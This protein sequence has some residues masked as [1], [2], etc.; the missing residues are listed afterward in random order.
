[1]EDARSTR[2]TPGSNADQSILL[3]FSPPNNVEF[4]WRLRKLLC[5]QMNVHDTLTASRRSYSRMD[6]EQGGPSGISS[7]DLDSGGK[8]DGVSVSKGHEGRSRP[9]ALDEIA[10]DDNR[11]DHV[12]GSNISTAQADS[13]DLSLLISQYLHTRPHP[14][15]A[16]TFDEEV[17]GIGRGRQ[18]QEDIE[19]IERALLG[20]SKTMCESN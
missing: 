15:L 14:T 19:E 6:G 8:K 3:V 18:K 11:L 13:Q 7:R 1:M 16:R 9:I 10:L 4:T 12:S 20:T 17:L 5:P 2:I